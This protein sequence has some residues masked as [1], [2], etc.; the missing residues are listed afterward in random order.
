MSK[1]GR[2][3]I[4]AD[5]LQRSE[6]GQKV[7]G[8]VCLQRRM[9]DRVLAVLSDGEGSGVR[10]NVTAGVIGSMAVN[11][12][13]NDVPAAHAA[14]AIIRTF[15]SEH[16]VQGGHATFSILD[17]RENG[18]V[19]VVEFENPRYIVL[20]GGDEYLPPRAAVEVEVT[21]SLSQT[22]YV[23]EFRARPED[24]IVLLSDGVTLSGRLTRRLPEGWRR[25]GVVDF[26]LTATAC[27]PTLSAHELC[28]R[29]IERA[30]MNDLFAP[31]NDMSCMAVYFRQP[32]RILVCTGPPFKAENDAV[33]ADMVA[34]YEGSKLICGGTTAQIISRELG[35][36]V[37]VVLRRDPAALPPTST[38]EG[39]DLVTEGVLTLS[40]VKSLLARA[41]A[42]E[43]A[44]RGTDG[45]VARLLLAHDVI[46]FAVGTR[47]NPMHQ[48]PS[49]PVELE[50]R[51]N[52]V[53]DLAFLLETKFMKHVTIRYI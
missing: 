15:I 13:M 14:A 44:E 45:E 39:V 11:Y 19:R 30:E 4:E 42:S 12:T 1:S 10:A 29:V 2:F 35:R 52:L 24:R 31:K 9:G 38:M 21:P 51:R 27:D 7:S 26:C 3:F 34:R 28:R 18:A 40:K 53:R 25:G 17:I 33:L 50:L 6:Q 49:L 22:I 48:D 32:R 41:A 43:I 16:N 46:E 5:C 8:D 47:I 23:S 20:R 36:P 37:S